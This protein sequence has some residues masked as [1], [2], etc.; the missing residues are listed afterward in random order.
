MGDAQ[1]M[2]EAIIKLLSDPDLAGQMGEAGRQR[3]EEHFTMEHVV[4]KV[5]SIYDEF[6]ERQIKKPVLQAR[7]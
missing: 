5:E 7:S 6:C 4:R 1:S 2:A 3:V